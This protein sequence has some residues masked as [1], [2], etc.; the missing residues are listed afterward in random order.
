[1]RATAN[2]KPRH[3]LTLPTR[4]C[5]GLTAPLFSIM[6]LEGERNARTVDL[7]HRSWNADASSTPT[8]EAAHEIRRSEW[9]EPAPGIVLCALLPTDS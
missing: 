5:C 7:D 1:M 6:T 3:N 8:W 9:Q 2:L 4:D